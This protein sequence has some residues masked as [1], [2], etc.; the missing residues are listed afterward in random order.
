MMTPAQIK[1]ASNA[2]LALRFN[3]R[4]IG[5]GGADNSVES[6]AMGLDKTGRKQAKKTGERPSTRLKPGGAGGREGSKT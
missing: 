1:Q 6:R 3:R 2:V 5:A 4:Y